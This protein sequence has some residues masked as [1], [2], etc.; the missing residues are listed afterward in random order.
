ME[1]INLNFIKTLEDEQIVLMLQNNEMSEY[2]CK[3][4][5][6]RY[7]EKIMDRCSS[8]LKNDNNKQDV[9]HE[10]LCHVLLKIPSFQFKSKFSTW[11]FAVVNNKCVDHLRKKKKDKETVISKQIES[12]LEEIIEDDVE[13][14]RL[15]LL[16]VALLTIKPKELSLIQD[17]FVN[18][19]S[20]K[21]MA[22]YYNLSESSL[23]MKLLR[24]K[25]KLN[26]KLSGGV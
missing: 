26:K 3:V 12:E 7:Y 13:A 22:I 16:E 20:Y 19:K 1:K 17:K 15:D 24:V 2:S 11:L 8:Y 4:L 18:N 10:I 21:E 9:A 23:K 14:L 6:D 5:S 25:K